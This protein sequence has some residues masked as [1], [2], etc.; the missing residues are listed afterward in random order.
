MSGKSGG[1]DDPHALLKLDDAA[2]LKIWRELEESERALIPVADRAAC[3]ERFRKLNPWILAA[4]VSAQASGGRAGRASRAKEPEP[5]GLI[6]TGSG[7]IAGCEH[8]AV[9]LLREAPQYMQLHY[10]DFL[11]RP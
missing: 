8:N 2:F 10:D 6:R 7:A 9:V 11:D 3:T 4:P 5:G 1:G